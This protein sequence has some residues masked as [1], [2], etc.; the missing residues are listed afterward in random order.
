MKIA[1]KLTL[2]GCALIL[3]YVLIKWL[4]PPQLIEI[5]LPPSEPL[6]DGDYIIGHSN[7]SERVRIMNSKA[8]AFK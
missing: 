6:P 8:Y 2:I 7:S 5:D 1:K 3:G 4:A